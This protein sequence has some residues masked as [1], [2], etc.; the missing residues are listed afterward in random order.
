M[1]EFF[2]PCWN[3]FCP[4]PISTEG[5]FPPCRNFSPFP[6]YFP[7]KI[8]SLLTEGIPAYLKNIPLITASIVCR[9]IP[10][11]KEKK[12]KI[13]NKKEEDIRPEC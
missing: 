13:E 7:E 12:K 10:Q 3:Y 4:F 6:P 5:F 8:P 9:A 2:R 11:R 1:S